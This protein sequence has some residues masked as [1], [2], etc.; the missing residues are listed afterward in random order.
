MTSSS[1]GDA[2]R[3]LQLVQVAEPP[4]G[5][6]GPAR[7]CR[8][9]S[10]PGCQAPQPD[11]GRAAD[12]DGR[13]PRVGRAPAAR[14]RHGEAGLRA[15]RRP[16]RPLC[17]TRRGAARSRAAARGESA[18]RPAVSARTKAIATPTISSR[19]KPRTIG[20]GESWRTRKPAAVARQAV[21]IV[22]PPRARGCPRRLDARRGPLPPPRRSGP[23][24][25][26]RS[27][28]RGRSG[29]AGRRSRPS[30]ASRRGGRRGRR[31]SPR[32]RARAPAAAA[33][34]ASGRR[35]S[36]ISAITASATAKRTQQRV[37]E[38]PCEAVDDDRGAGDD[39]AAALRARS[40]AR[41]CPSSAQALRG[42]VSSTAASISPIARWRSAS[43]RS[44][45][46][47]TTICA[48]WPFGKR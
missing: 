23:G 16:S 31:R 35:A 30:S 18:A 42:V 14:G 32:R 45:F 17:A 5:S 40:R 4:A 38:R 41:A 2:G 7:G 28:R 27:R 33:A 20:V 34:G 39:V 15:R 47:R 36:R 43:L 11:D 46:S 44:G 13:E 37:L 21:A 8:R 22:G 3:V 12:A 9:R 29:S 6:A 10:R 25:G 19:P 1:P 24:T 48:E 26:S